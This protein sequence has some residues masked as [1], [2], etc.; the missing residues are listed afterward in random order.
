MQKPTG[1][2]EGDSQFNHHRILCSQKEEDKRRRFIWTRSNRSDGW[3]QAR[4]VFG[5]YYVFAI[6]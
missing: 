1:Y 4:R 2:R 3:D 5:I 6:I